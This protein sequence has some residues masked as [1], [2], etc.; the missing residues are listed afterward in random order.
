M[1]LYRAGEF[2]SPF[3]TL[4]FAQ[5]LVSLAKGVDHPLKAR[6]VFTRPPGRV[7]VAVLGVNRPG[8]H[9]PFG[10]DALGQQLVQD[11]LLIFREIL[12]V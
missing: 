9:G 3:L 12:F 8:G 6:E 4:R 7:G 5:L 1:V 10:D 2:G 11:G